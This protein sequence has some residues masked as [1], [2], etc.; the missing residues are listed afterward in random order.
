MISMGVFNHEQH[1]AELEQL[2]RGDFA[3]FKIQPINVS[4]G[5]IFPSEGGNEGLFEIEGNGLSMLPSTLTSKGG[6]DFG[7]SFSTPS[8]QSHGS[9]QSVLYVK[10][11]H[12]ENPWLP[13]GIPS[14]T[15]TNPSTI[16]AWCLTFFRFWIR[17]QNSS[18]SGTCYLLI[19]RGVNFY[20]STGAPSIIGAY[21]SPFQNWGK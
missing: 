20:G 7:E 19:T 6:S 5:G 21:Q 1:V 9:E 18:G 10:F 15:D 8:V 16:T 17:V 4:T 14:S 13:I 3:Q 12:K 2:R 11:N